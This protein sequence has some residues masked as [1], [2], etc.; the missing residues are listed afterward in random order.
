MNRL[1]TLLLASAAAGAFAQ[2]EDG[3]A[4]F[5]FEEFETGEEPDLFILDG[6]YTVEADGENKVLQLGPAPLTEGSIQLGKSLK[7]GGE[8]TGRIKAG[9]KR[10]SYPRFALGLHGMSGFKLRVFPI[11]KQVELVRGEEEPAATAAF[12]EWK[13][14]TW[15][16]LKLRV[17]GSQEDGWKVEGWVWMEGAEPTEEP[18]ISHEIEGTRLQGKGSVVGTPYAGLPIWYDDIVIKAVAD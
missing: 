17:T 2:D 15:T 8:I 16:H 6:T 10:R 11:K 9:S 12:S 1:L 13:G 5:D 14:D 4:K 18:L 7:T 3:P